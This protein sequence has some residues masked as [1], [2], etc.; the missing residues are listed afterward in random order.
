MARRIVIAMIMKRTICAFLVA[1]LA[2]GITGVTI[3]A[4]ARGETQQARL[5]NA[6]VAFSFVSYLLSLTFGTLVFLVLQFLKRESIFSYS[7]CG[8]AGGALYGF[9]S[10]VIQGISWSAFLFFSLLGF[11]VA[12]TFALI[13]GKPKQMLVSQKSHKIHLP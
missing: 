2:A 1:P 6:F 5:G 12:L 11:S 3:M 10:A 7:L 13:R 4:M 9:P 8:I